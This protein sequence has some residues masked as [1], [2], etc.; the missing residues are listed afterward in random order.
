MPHFTICN[1]NLR[2]PQNVSVKVQLKTPHRSLY[3]FEN[4]YYA[5]E[6]LLPSPFSIIGL[7]K[8]DTLIKEKN[9]CLVFIITSIALKS[10]IL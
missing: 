8:S 2:C 1:I 3:H 10:C 7:Y 4:A 9:I 5:N 6:L